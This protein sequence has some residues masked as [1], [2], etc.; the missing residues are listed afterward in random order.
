MRFQLAVLALSLIVA[1]PSFVAAQDDNEEKPTPIQLAQY[2]GAPFEDRH[3]NLWFGTVLEGLIRY[4]GNEFVTFTE[5]DGLGSNMIR[6]IVEDEE[7]VLWI[8]TSGGLTKYDGETFTTLTNYEPITVTQGWSE[9][10]NH[11]ELWDVMIDSRGGL[12]ITTAD[13]VFQYDGEIF[14]RFEMPVVAVDRKW[15]FTPRNVSCVFEDQGGDLWFGTD[16]AGAVRYDGKTMVVYTV[17]THGLS[18]DNVSSIFQDSR[19]D[20]WFGT[21]NGGVSHFDGNTFTTHLRSKEF[22]KHSGWGRYF[23]I[24][25]DRQGYVWFGAAYEGGGAYRYDGESFEYFTGDPGL[26]AGGVTSIREDRSGNLW[27]GTTGGVYHFDGERFTN[28]TKNDPQLP[29][30]INEA[31]PTTDAHESDPVSVDDWPSETIMLPPGFAPE[32]PTGKEMLLF[33]PGWRDSDADE[34][35]SYAF[36]MWI[37]EPAPDAARIDELLESYYDGLMS[38]L[39][40]EEEIEK[41]NGPA[42][43]E[44]VRT[45]SNKFEATIRLIDGLTTLKPL[46]LHAMIETDNESE[47]RTILRVKVSPQPKAHKIWRSLNSAIEA[48]EST[49]N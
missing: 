49:Y 6:G 12:W 20:Y 43:V 28:F 26:G 4:D 44:V 38:A 11:R 40:I 23:A 27:F 7:G 35:W 48:I 33:A 2:P 18:S 29:A 47:N 25:E 16:G 10:G 8:A 42:Q 19:G 39:G 1:T 15:L 32:M 17:K 30:P 22:S 37:D 9:H 21:A 13:G 41:D 14:T 45:G 3:G 46:D 31:D 34:F 5:E 36:V 24:H